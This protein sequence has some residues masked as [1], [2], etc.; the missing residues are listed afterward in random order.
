MNVFRRQLTLLFAGF[1]V[2][3]LVAPTRSSAQR[4]CDFAEF[5]RHA[6]AAVGQ[7][8]G[9]P[10]SGDLTELRQLGA[11]GERCL[12]SLT[13]FQK[14]LGHYLTGYVW[15]SLGVANGDGSLLDRARSHF[16]RAVQSY[17]A[18]YNRPEMLETSRLMVGW[19]LARRGDL[20]GDVNVLGKAV[21]A[22]GTVG[23]PLRTDAI[24]LRGLVRL[25]ESEIL[26]RSALAG[27][28]E[29]VTDSALTTLK[30]AVQDLNAVRRNARDASLRASAAYWAGEAQV[31]VAKVQ[32][33]LAL[34]GRGTLPEKELANLSE[35]FDQLTRNQGLVSSV[36]RASQVAAVYTKMANAVARLLRELDFRKAD[37]IDLNSLGV[38]SSPSD[39][40][41]S[42]PGEQ[43]N[44]CQVYFGALFGL[45]PGLDFQAPSGDLAFWADWA[46]LQNFMVF[47]NVWN[48]GT[49][50]PNLASWFS[51]TDG[52]VRLRDLF[53]NATLPGAQQAI[54]AEYAWARAIV[55]ATL[56]NPVVALP[57]AP[58]QLW[59]QE[60]RTTLQN[61]GPLAELARESTNLIAPPPLPRLTNPGA[62]G[63]SVRMCL[64]LGG[65][66]GR[67]W[68]RYAFFLLQYPEAKNT[69]GTVQPVL[70]ELARYLG[71]RNDIRSAVAS[72]SHQELW[73]IYNRSRD[74]STKFA[75]LSALAVVHLFQGDLCDTG[76]GDDVASACRKHAS[77]SPLFAY[78]GQYFCNVSDLSNSVLQVARCQ[79]SHYPDLGY[80]WWN[81]KVQSGPVA[82]TCESPAQVK[83]EYRADWWLP[84]FSHLSPARELYIK[85]RHRTGMFWLALSP[86]PGVPQFWRPEQ[87]AS[88]HLPG[89]TEFRVQAQIPVSLEL[90]LPGVA[91]HVVLTMNDQ[92]VLNQTVTD[93]SL[94][95]KCFSGQEYGIL[96]WADGTW[97]TFSAVSFSTP[98]ETKRIDLVR[99]PQPDP[100]S[101]KTYETDA[102][103]RFPLWW[104]NGVTL[105]TS[106][107]GY[108]SQLGDKS[109][110]PGENVGSTVT[111]AVLV[112]GEMLALD[113]LRNRLVR[114]SD[115]RPFDL[116]R[117]LGRVR[118]LAAW[119]SQVYVLGERGKVVVLTA[120][121][122]TPAR[123]FDV[124]SLSIS[125]CRLPAVTWIG[126]MS[127]PTIWA[128]SDAGDTTR[129]LGVASA[130]RDGLLA[131]SRILYDGKSNYAAVVDLLSRK[132][133]FFLPN[134]E[135][136][137]FVKL[138][139]EVEW[140]WLS[141]SLGG[142]GLTVR[143]GVPGAIR[144][145][146]YRPGA[147]YAFEPSGNYQVPEQPPTIP[148]GGWIVVRTTW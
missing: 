78:A 32:A 105:W 134:G 52:H 79:V 47:G 29:T 62:L 8:V 108:A 49:S 77:E 61:V 28:A 127:G 24:Y 38:N 66:L 140:D 15:Y 130:V 119:G 55:R 125:I 43:A 138:P 31:L 85:L 88:L 34:N 65:L 144:E 141:W 109:Y 3:G 107:A 23:E 5:Q 11:T 117:E 82:A 45:R 22:L 76:P 118:D 137:G 64:T 83:N 100:Q 90:G 41:G 122:L 121:D 142:D 67:Q 57:K 19:A 10:S 16:Q 104:Q 126:D 124:P 6:V 75:A 148:T 99:A 60:V 111:R 48:L 17:D 74:A 139:R 56:G 12:S 13:G 46:K 72:Q 21:D 93:A 101:T 116:P 18:A 110:G 89:P 98:G 102:E 27:L 59:P 103:G 84:E 132:L 114:A 7:F 71:A 70:A 92:T 69:F 35:S 80:Q 131:P 40:C 145:A 44:I 39:F 26:F 73:R 1:L 129:L 135:Y 91:K 58:S 63:E 9:S 54:A 146:V 106:E 81:F 4:D 147:T 113:E 133:F 37:R 33:L 30:L 25:R 14:F 123:T 95:L 51:G 143:F 96:A 86:A 128:V 115:G 53:T 120:P 50:V 68:Y 112:G 97:P 20:A 42:L 2:A 136:V 36:R 94:S 87:L